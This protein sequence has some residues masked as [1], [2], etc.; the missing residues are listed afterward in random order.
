MK[1]KA[2]SKYKVAKARILE[3]IVGILEKYDVIALIDMTGL[4]AN[5]LQK[6]RAMMREGVELKIFKNTLL[7]KAIEKIQV[8]KHEFERLKNRL[9]GSNAF[10]FTNESAFSLYTYLNK[11]KVYAKAKLGD[12]ATND[13]LIPEGNTG[14][15][16]GPLLSL[17]K[18][19]KIPT[20]VVEGS[21]YVAKDSLL[22]KKGEVVSKEAADL[23]SKLNMEPLEVG[24]N[25]KLAYD[26]GL[27]LTGKELMLDLDLY[28]SQLSEAYS[29][30]LKL[31]I[32]IVYPT[33][34]N[35]KLLLAKAY[36]EA[37]ALSINALLPVKEALEIILQKAEAQARALESAI[38]TH[39]ET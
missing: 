3:S 39:L 29:N 17:F 26:N 25:I 36:N 6:L 28:R 23:L 14:L 1:A 22:V 18:T 20:R 13:I 4:R 19:L 12:K 7:K 24:L 5:Q 34:D 8:R 2:L 16:S 33:S 31:S 15:P 9:E 38:S 10:I 27:I 32:G 35:I 11:V 37:R 21:I 30:A